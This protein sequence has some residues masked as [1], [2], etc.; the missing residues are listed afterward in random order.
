MV[1]EGAGDDGRGHLGD[2]VPITVEAQEPLTVEPT[3]LS[4]ARVVRSCS[5]QLYQSGEGAPVFSLGGRRRQATRPRPR[6]L[7]A[8]APVRGQSYDRRQA[9]RGRLLLLRG[10]LDRLEGEGADKVLSSE[11]WAKEQY[12]HRDDNLHFKDVHTTKGLKAGELGRYG[13][14]RGGAHLTKSGPARRSG[15]VAQIRQMV[16]RWAT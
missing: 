16:A 5:A 1:A 7:L 14:S 2:G 9:D 15:I 6:R 10:A 12:D 13:A 8:K 4:A 11:G 3:S